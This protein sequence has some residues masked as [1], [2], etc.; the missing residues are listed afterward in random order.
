M[1]FLIGMEFEW[2]T[3]ARRPEMSAAMFSTRFTAAATDLF[4]P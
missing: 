4:Y 3:T 1:V 2:A